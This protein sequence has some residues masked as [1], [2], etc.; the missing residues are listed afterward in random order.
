MT[1][2]RAMRNPDSVSPAVL[3]SVQRAI[4]KSGYVPNRVAG[5]LSSNRT[6]VVA[7]II[8]SLRNA[9]YAEMIKG[10]SDVLSRSNLHLMISDSGL[11][12]QEEEKLVAEYVAQRV[13][14]IILHNT[15]HTQRTVDMLRKSATACVETGNLTSTPID[16]VVSYSNHAAG[17]AMAEHLL[18]LG[19]RRFAFASL[20]V[21]RSERLRQ[22][23]NGFLA[24]LRKAGIEIDP[25]LLLEV[26][27]GLNSG[28]QALADVLARAPRTQAV[29]FAGDVLAAGA[30]FECQR[31]G[32][33]VPKR[34]AI[35][36]SD[37]NDLMQNMV[38]PITT[39]AFPRYEIGVRSAEM[40]V[41][42]GA[43]EAVDATRV[44]LGFSVI[45][46]G[47]T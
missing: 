14:G 47:S 17:K 44:D 29:F 1:V 11:D 45:Q 9:L 41:A 27:A 40:I 20:P 26:D 2:S 31:R 25:A 6:S 3:K 15:K 35:A 33:D 32:L 12:L 39:V 38:P 4:D 7:L 23:R 43:G 22:R 34:I 5:N 18:G 21:A 46:R 37:D 13:C 8:P 28:A 19:Y 10:I 42:R 16:M 36:A 30:I 24:G